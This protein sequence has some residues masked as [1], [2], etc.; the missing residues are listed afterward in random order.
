MLET[1]HQKIK[2]SSGS[3]L[4]VHFAD[5]LPRGNESLIDLIIWNLI[6]SPLAGIILTERF[7]ALNDKMKKKKSV[8]AL[9]SEEVTLLQ[10]EVVLLRKKIRICEEEL[11]AKCKVELRRYSLPPDLVETISN[12]IVTWAREWFK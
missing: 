3:A 11:D 4:E 12:E 2:D 8:V 10:N 9:T 1:L 5:H 6:L 7:K